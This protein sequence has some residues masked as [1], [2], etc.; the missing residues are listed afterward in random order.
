MQDNFTLIERDSIPSE[1]ETGLAEQGTYIYKN[2]C[3]DG[4]I[5]YPDFYN[6]CVQEYNE[7]TMYLPWV[8][9][10]LTED[11]PIGENCFG[12]AAT[13]VHQSYPVYQ[14]FDG[15]I[16]TNWLTTSYIKDQ[17]PV[18]VI[19]YNPIALN[20]TKLIITNRY[21]N[22]E[23]ATIITQ[24][25]IL[26]S[27]DGIDYE[28]IT[29]ITNDNNIISGQWE[30]D[31]CENQQ[32]YCYYKLHIT[33]FTL[34]Y[35]DFNLGLA[36]IDIIA[37]QAI[38]VHDNGHM[39][40]DMKY[41]AGVDN[42]YE[43]YN[44][45]WFYG[46]DQENEC[47]FLPRN[48][49][50][51][52][53]QKDNKNT[54]NNSLKK[55]LY[56]CV[57]NTKNVVTNNVNTMD[58]TTSDND[59]M[60]LGFSC[61]QKGIVTSAGWL[62]SQGQWNDGTIYESFYNMC[63]NKQGQQ[64]AAGFIKLVNEDYNDYDLVLDETNRT[65]R[66]P[67]LN[68]EEDVLSKDYIGYEEPQNNTYHVAPYNGIF[69]FAKVGSA[70]KYACI[71]KINDYNESLYRTMGYTNI[72]GGWCVVNMECNAGDV[73]KIGYTADKSFVHFRFCPYKGNGDLYFKV[74]NAV[75]NIELIDV[76]STLNAIQELI[77]NNKQLISSYASPSANFVDLQL[78]A[79]NSTYEMPADGYIT[80]GKQSTSSGS[81][82]ALV[83]RAT[84][85][86]AI[87]FAPNSNGNNL[88]VTLPVSKGDVIT[89]SYNATGNILAFRFIYAKGSI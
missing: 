34:G 8:Q 25:D 29:S 75:Q 4:T 40:Y 26:G 28:H 71:E 78:G 52:D 18:D 63:I 37:T 82:V 35:D 70:D 48:N 31:L 57:G 43:Q 74:G 30:I 64:F 50:F 6:Q 61:Y 76:Q 67:L 54:F 47:I 51:L 32:F 10:I 42:I 1:Q 68:G 41:K 24:A 16:N 69:S 14:L 27:N 33:D 36:Q 53:P 9:P 81:H 85:M 73:V 49:E 12:V 22:K 19:I 15:N 80:F 83:N 44:K 20:I 13:D 58:I 84:N 60:P 56:I 66:L 62:K 88:R 55:H 87:V 21:M 79:T 59:L 45:A 77:P 11:K 2:A 23:V 5:G 86:A 17:L 72:N 89:V 38:K 46:I 65:F 39:F 7:A 3:A